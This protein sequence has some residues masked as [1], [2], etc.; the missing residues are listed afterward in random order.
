[1]NVIVPTKAFTYGI[2][3]KTLITPIKVSDK[4]YISNDKSIDICIWYLMKGL[5]PCFNTRAKI[6]YKN[7]TIPKVKYE[8]TATIFSIGYI[9]G[10]FCTLRSLP[11]YI[12]YFVYIFA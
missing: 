4:T 8:N 3:P 12:L 2:N 11:A 1:M 6:I 7:P 9:T 5:K 10:L